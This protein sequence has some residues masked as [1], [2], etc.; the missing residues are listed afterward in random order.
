MMVTYFSFMLFVSDI[1]A[2]QYQVTH[3]LLTWKMKWQ[4]TIIQEGL[5]LCS[6]GEKD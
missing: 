5:G 4:G 2:I 6:C 3:P 1:S